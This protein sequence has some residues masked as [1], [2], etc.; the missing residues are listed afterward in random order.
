MLNAHKTVVKKEDTGSWKSIQV[1]SK[2]LLNHQ[3]QI[4]GKV[5]SINLQNLWLA[6]AGVPGAGWTRLSS[7][8]L[9]SNTL[10][11]L[12][13]FKVL[14]YATCFAFKGL[15]C[16]EGIKGVNQDQTWSISRAGLSENNAL[17]RSA[18]ALTSELWKRLKIWSST[19]RREERLWSLITKCLLPQT[20]THK[21]MLLRLQSQ[22]WW[23]CFQIQRSRTEADLPHP[24]LLPA[25]VLI[26]HTTVGTIITDFKAKHEGQV[27]FWFLLAQ[28]SQVG[29]ERLQF[30]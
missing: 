28:P 22:T 4:P 21:L 8:F 10:L 6:A 2:K 11:S 23:W 13:C 18:P 16:A 26:P 20:Q 7:P 14:L 15:L 30:T 12:G 24:T 29:S 25:K 9:P 27:L 1:P 19:W 3:M 5:Y 17:Q